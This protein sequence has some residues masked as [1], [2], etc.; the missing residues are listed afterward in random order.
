MTK[1]QSTL[2]L[3]STALRTWHYYWQEMRANWRYNLP[4][5]I[6][7]PLAY[8]LATFLPGWLMSSVI[9]ILTTNP[10]V[11]DEVW[12]VFWPYIVGY[13]ISMIVGEVLLKRINMRIG[14]KSEVVSIE[15]LH[16]KCFSKLAD[17]SMSFHSDKFGGSLVSQLKRFVSSYERLMDCIF[18]TILPLA[19]TLILTFAILGSQLP[20]FTLVLAILVIGF[21]FFAIL[22]F[23]KTSEIVKKE[24]ESDSEITGQLADVMINIAATKSY[25]HE[26]YEYKLYEKRVAKWQ[27]YV[28]QE[29]RRFFMQGIGFG[30]FLSLIAIATF[31]F[32]VGGNAWFGVSIGTLVLAVTYMLQIWSQLW[33]FNNILKDMNRVFG[34]AQ[35]M[36]L[37]LDAPVAVK[38]I[39][40]APDLVVSRGEVDFDHVNFHHSDTTEELFRDFNLRIPAGQR[41]GLVGHS[42]SGK[43]TLTKLLLRFADVTNGA[44]TIDG[45][46][47]S[48]VTQESL[49]KNIA[50]VPQE[51]LLF[52]RSIADNI[53]YGKLNASIDEVR[54]AAKLANALDF[55]EKL[56]KGFD[57]LTGER[58]VKLSGGQRQRVAIARA[59]LKDA[60]ILIMDEA[61]SALDTESE[62]MIQDALKN[63]MKGRTSIIIAH[64]LSTVAELDRIL[65]MQDGKIIEDGTHAELIEKTGVYSRLWNRQTGVIEE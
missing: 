23:R 58:G 60:P 18:W 65:V 28:M 29:M 1:K 57:T 48:D 37:I 49:R 24:A 50:Y 36:T 53:K 25:A 31:I 2:K 21:M 30:G 16:K 5:L 33:S 26:D 15:R 9:N 35:E 62:K 3:P 7:T 56:P 10:P 44:I 46:N 42:G 22:T 39:A 52:H 12:A 47:I 55:I 34:D 13:I 43:T 41:V 61:T 32:L 59:I 54:H 17:Q 14:W 40:D 20:E 64:R 8:F 45:Q 51:P 4:I 38:N 19:S 11:K 27:K 63:L 6:T